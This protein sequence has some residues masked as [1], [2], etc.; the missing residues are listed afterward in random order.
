MTCCFLLRDACGFLPSAAADCLLILFRI[1]LMMVCCA[2]LQVWVIGCIA[3]AAPL[4]IAKGRP[5]D[6]AVC[7]MLAGIGYEGEAD[8][9]HEMGVCRDS[10]PGLTGYDRQ[11]RCHTDPCLAALGSDGVGEGDVR[12]FDVWLSWDSP[13]TTG[14]VG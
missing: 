13:A 7:A 6:H 2:L 8:H 3:A 12:G 11:R 5:I 4:C 14:S 9:L 1:L 10:R